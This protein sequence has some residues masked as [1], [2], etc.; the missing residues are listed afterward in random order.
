[1]QL[2]PQVL[3]LFH[4]MP[5]N[6][7]TSANSPYI[8]LIDYAK[9]R[10]VRQVISANTT[11]DPT[12]EYLLFLGSLTT[13]KGATECLHI[14]QRAQVSVQIFLLSSIADLAP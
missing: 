3:Q 9:L 8:W 4:H 6:Y 10:S 12:E 5:K 2:C 11:K 13:H 14:Y 7:D 1:M